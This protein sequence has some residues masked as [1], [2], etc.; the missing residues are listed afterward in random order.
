MDRSPD[1]SPEAIIDLSQPS[2]SKSAAKV[3]HFFKP[4]PTI[5]VA[6]A[7]DQTGFNWP[8]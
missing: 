1:L 7:A 5:A 3:Y 6:K 2:S 8:T 4:L